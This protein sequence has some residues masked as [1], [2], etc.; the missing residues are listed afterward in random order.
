VSGSSGAQASCY[1][2][3]V[4]VL[5]VIPCYNEAAR[6]DP[7][8]FRAWIEAHPGDRFLFVD[9]GS[10]DHTAE[11][12]ATLP[13]E[14]L[15]LPRNVGKSEAVR[16]GLRHGSGMG[17]ELIAVFDADLSAPLEAVEEMRARMIARPELLLVMGARVAMLGYDVRR[18]SL[19]HYGG[20]L[21]ATAT[22]MALGLPVY[23]TQCGAKLWRVGPHLLPLLE[24][25]FLGRWTY[26]VE[27]I[28][29]LMDGVPAGAPV[30]I[31]EVPLRR[32]HHEEG[33]KVR[34]VDLGRALVDLVR[35]R[36]RHRT[37]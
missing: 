1:Q 14:V 33:S 24:R 37:R 32:W 27:L 2:T 13:G 6:L 36:W 26:D 15:R 8:P 31:E 28:A 23:D 22:S 3:G 30:P 17:A 16:A 7:A 20:R 25:P 34:A 21:F 4:N 12:L 29:R 19:R 18:A 35:V 5:F 10:T 11:V 9:D